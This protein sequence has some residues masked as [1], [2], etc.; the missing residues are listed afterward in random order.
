MIDY[1]DYLTKFAKE[2][3]K[4]KPKMAKRIKVNVKKFKELQN[5][6]TKV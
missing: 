4:K 6:K 5:E 1:F 3:G 2:N